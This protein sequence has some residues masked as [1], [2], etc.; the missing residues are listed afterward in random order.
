MPRLHILG[1]SGSGTTTLAAA[2]CARHGWAHFDTD[3]FLWIK[4][5]PP[6]TDMRPREE[7]QAM[8]AAALDGARDWVGVGLDVRLGRC[9]HA[10]FRSGGVPVGA[11]RDPHP[12][13]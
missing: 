13:G 9:L 2:L 4:T 7:R 8:L 12:S 1:A 6:Y 3:D 10:A 5:D 11:D